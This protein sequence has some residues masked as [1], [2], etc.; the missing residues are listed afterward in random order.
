MNQPLKN[1]GE[2]CF[3]LCGVPLRT[4]RHEPSKNL[5]GEL[6]LGRREIRTRLL[7]LTASA[8]RATA[9]SAQGDDFDCVSGIQP[10]GLIDGAPAVHKN[11]NVRLQLACFIQVGCEN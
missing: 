8:H 9:A 4:T 11:V 1:N 7:T 3:Y 5:V 6:R 10:N 2:T